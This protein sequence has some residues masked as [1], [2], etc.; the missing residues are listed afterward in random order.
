VRDD[1]NLYPLNPK[2]KLGLGDVMD[3]GVYTILSGVM[4]LVG[5]AFLFFYEGEWGAEYYLEEYEEGFFANFE[6][7]L[8]TCLWIGIVLL[9][10]GVIIYAVGKKTEGPQLKTLQAA[11]KQNLDNMIR[12]LHDGKLPGEN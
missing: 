6:A 9:V 12:D 8:S 7:M 1:A 3:I 2:T 11:R 4:A 10:V 5:Y